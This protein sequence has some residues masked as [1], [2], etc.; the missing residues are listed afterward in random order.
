MKGFIVYSTYEAREDA[1]KILLFGRLENGES[2][3]AKVPFR[4]HFFIKEDDLKKAEAIG[5]FESE[6]TA[7]E[8]FEG[9]DVAKI[10]VNVPKEV[11]ELRKRFEEEGIVCFEADVKFA[12]RFLIDKNINGTL[13]IEG[14][15]AKGERV[16][17]IYDDPRISPIKREDFFPELRVL[18]MDIE[19]DRHAR[20]LYCISMACGDY[21]RVLAI[22]KEGESFR[23]A[24]IFHDEKALLDE[25]Q[26]RL[27]ELD[28]DII[29]GWNLIDFDLDFLQRRF[30]KQKIDFDFGRI[31]WPS[32]LRIESK[33]LIDSKADFPGRQV[34]D[35]IHLLKTSFVALEDYKLDTA[36]KNILGD[37]KLI[38]AHNKGEELERLFREDK[39][40]LIDYNLKDSELVLGILDKTDVVKL[41]ILRSML[42][43]MA[44]DRVRATI[45]SFDSLYLQHLRK[46]G[47]VAPTANYEQEREER[48]KGGFV[49][50]SKPGIYDN[51]VVLDF[52]SLYPSIMR[53]YNIDPLSFSQG[54]MADD[55]I[56]AAN[57][58]KFGREEGILPAILAN[59]WKE[60]D[61]ARKKKDEIA[62]YALKVLMNSFYGALGNP[63]CR[64]HSL[65]MANA[66]TH[67]AQH[68]IK[69]TMK[70]IEK[71]GFEV[72]YGDTDS[73]F[74]DTKKDSDGAAKV[75]EELRK[76]MNAFWEKK[77]KKEIGRDSYLEL[78][79][80]KLFTRFFMPTVRGAE[81]GSKKRY[82]GLKL[83]DGKEELSFTGLET[84]R[85]DWTALAKGFQQELFL[86]VFGKKDVKEYIK[87]TVADL[88]EGKLDD[89]LVYRKSITKGLDEYVK[90]TPP[91]VKA[92]RQMEEISSSIIE[93]YMT[94]DGPVPLE[95]MK[96][97]RIDYEHYI[98]KQLKPIADTILHAIG[99]DF[100]TIVNKKG[101]KTLGEY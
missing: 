20:E 97:K 62:R 57:G 46:R 64:F 98:E 78:E 66:I 49:M 87:R 27:I 1:A 8:N 29:T 83:K 61:D 7:L 96:G 90:T 72:I 50:Q 93:Y 89:S 92:A 30:K 13:D 47:Y 69:T 82:A 18:S 43:G 68:T 10:I 2:F 17:R 33:F 53:T 24:D 60:R 56:V 37:G 59:I 52:K 35:G 94:T 67:T 74:I 51:I 19:T 91:H 86:R 81:E 34:L 12:Q 45:A 11:P 77:I 84:V 85:R 4:P 28:P 79:F 99:E 48:A 21:R 70:E 39:Q 95:K 76:E 75:A 6:R 63:T 16:G 41:T 5:G 14:E 101:Q 80:D 22:G 32:K 9:K 36:A 88:K 38:D 73:I 25:F 100:D 31:N 58:A 55:P 65:D 3:L 42:T 54:K 15:Y 26:R 44:L 23:N 71:K 40:R